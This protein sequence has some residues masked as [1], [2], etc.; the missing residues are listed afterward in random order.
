[1][2]TDIN[3]LLHSLFLF[4]IRDNIKKINNILVLRDRV[5][6]AEQAITF[7]FFH[8]IHRKDENKRSLFALIFFSF[9]R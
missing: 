3:A 4:N 2:Q 1:M 8:P 5:C 9:C 6:P 7:G